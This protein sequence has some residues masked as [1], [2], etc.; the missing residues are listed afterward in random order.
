MK[1]TYTEKIARS[2][3]FQVHSLLSLAIWIVWLSA[4]GKVS[5]SPIVCRL[6]REPLRHV[7]TF[8]SLPKILDSVGDVLQHFCRL[9]IA[10]GKDGLELESWTWNVS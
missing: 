9:P 10:E 5:G 7:S 1:E 3:V 4:Y 6:R 2:S 8:A